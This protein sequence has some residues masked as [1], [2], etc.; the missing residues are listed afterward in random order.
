MNNNL[1]TKETDNRHKMVENGC[2]EHGIDVSC[3]F[4]SPDLL[5]RYERARDKLQCSLREGVWDNVTLPV[6]WEFDSCH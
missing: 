2:V 1:H 6:S 4:T 3:F 5:F